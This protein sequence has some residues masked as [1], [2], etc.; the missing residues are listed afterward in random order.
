MTR[1][2]NVAAMMTANSEPPKQILA[3]PLLQDASNINVWQRADGS[4]PAGD[5]WEDSELQDGDTLVWDATAED[6][7]PGEAAGAVATTTDMYPHSHNGPS[8]GGHLYGFWE[9]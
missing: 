7:K 9:T 5:G 4:A 6:W 8:D 1:P 3:R 2:Y